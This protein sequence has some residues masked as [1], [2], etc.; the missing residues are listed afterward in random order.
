MGEITHISQILLS[1]LAGEIAVGAGVEK[2]GVGTLGSPSVT[3]MLTPS[4][5]SLAPMLTGIYNDVLLI[6][7]VSTEDKVA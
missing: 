2:G 7:H 4:S 6:V 3:R 1:V 5:R